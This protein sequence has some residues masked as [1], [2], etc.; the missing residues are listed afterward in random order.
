MAKKKK[1][2]TLA[3]RKAF[4]VKMAKYRKAPRR[5]KRNPTK[6]QV[7]SAAAKLAK[8]A[9]ALAWAATKSSA[10]FGGRVAKASAKAAAKEVKDSICR[11]KNP[12]RRKMT[13]WTASARAAFARRMAKY[14]KAPKARPRMKNRRAMT[15]TKRKVFIL[16]QNGR[17]KLWYNGA[18]FSNQSKAVYFDSIEKAKKKAHALLKQYPVLEKYSVS[19][20]AP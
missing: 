12:K 5:R 19:L 11:Q 13:K 15:G 3:M 17:E 9:G 6:E 1:V 7:K 10:K 4:A 2:W 8:R 20:V 16:A 14:R 18:H